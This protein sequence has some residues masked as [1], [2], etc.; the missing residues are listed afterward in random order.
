MPLAIER[1]ANT[2]FHSEAKL[3]TWHPRGVFDDDVADRMVE[4]LEFEEDLMGPFNRYTDLNGLTEIRLRFGH[5]F[6][7]AQR[8]RERFAG[9]QRVKSA[10]FCDWVIGT[11]LART[12]EAMMIGASIKVRA[13]R[14]RK[15]AADWLAVPLELLAPES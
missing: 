5:T 2:H 11:G 14:T 1:I 7:L 10:I 15:S 9:E 6:E 3:L 12:Y 4:F 8:R 13:F